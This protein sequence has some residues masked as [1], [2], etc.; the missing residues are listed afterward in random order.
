VLFLGSQVNDLNIG[1]MMIFLSHKNQSTTTLYWCWSFFV[2]N[3]VVNIQNNIQNNGGKGLLIII[4]ELGKFLEYSA[5][6]ESDDIF[7]LQTLAE[8]TYNNNIL[9]FVLLHQSFEQYGKN[10]NTKLKNE[11][12]K[13][14]GRYEVLSFIETITQSLHIMGRVFQNQLSKTQ[15]K[16]IQTKIKNT[17]KVLQE[18]NLLPV[19]L[20]TKTA[21][22]LFENCYQLHLLLD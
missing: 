7:L 12:T 1:Q 22:H 8:A 17:V 6:H 11:W 3:L 15:L 19:S 10:L 2:C 9:L 16:P 5:R 18:N 21:H 13:I 14:Q 4:D 20:D